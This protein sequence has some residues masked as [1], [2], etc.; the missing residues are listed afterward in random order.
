MIALLISPKIE[1]L[2]I[3]WTGHKIVRICMEFYN[4]CKAPIAHC[5]NVRALGRVSYID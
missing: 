3:G 2:W 5:R 4:L 1:F